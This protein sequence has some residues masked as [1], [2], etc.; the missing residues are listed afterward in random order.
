M[1][2][3]GYREIIYSDSKLMHFKTQNFECL[4]KAPQ[5][6]GDENR[7]WTNQALNLKGGHRTKF[8]KFK[9][10]PLVIKCFIVLVERKRDFPKIP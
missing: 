5:R 7:S 6:T 2:S 1:I 9:E 4:K 3:I 10:K 8:K